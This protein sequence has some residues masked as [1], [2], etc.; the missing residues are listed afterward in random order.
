M[1]ISVGEIA[2]VLAVAETPDNPIVISV[3]E[4]APTEAVAP[5][6]V[7]S[8]NSTEATVIDPIE[9]VAPKP[10]IP[11]TSAGAIAPVADV[12]TKEAKP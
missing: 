11:I 1:V 2:P 4:I 10:E 7:T 6:P 9:I 3:G 12:A 5:T 8:T